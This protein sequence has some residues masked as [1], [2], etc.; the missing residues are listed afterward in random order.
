MTVNS[1]Y[2]KDTVSFH[3]HSTYC[4]THLYFTSTVQFYVQWV[5]ING[6]VHS[7]VLIEDSGHSANFG[8][9][10]STE[11]NCVLADEIPPYGPLFCYGLCPRLHS[12]AVRLLNAT[13]GANAAVVV[14]WSTVTTFSLVRRVS[15]YAYK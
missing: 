11:N 9:N 7:R 12:S 5:R 1:T 10:R 14:S 2:A 4:R 3:L 13:P 8:E 15:V 6:T